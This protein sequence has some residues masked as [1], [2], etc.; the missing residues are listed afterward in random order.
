MRCN[1]DVRAY[2]LSHGVFLYELGNAL[3]IKGDCNFSRYL[4]TERSDEEKRRMLDI[5]NEI[6]ESRR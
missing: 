4:R 6:A 1:N 2:A 3:G 5:I